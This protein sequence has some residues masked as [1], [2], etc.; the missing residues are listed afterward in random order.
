MPPTWVTNGRDPTRAVPRD[1]KP[2]R[3][4]ICQ[5]T[6]RFRIL[7]A[8][9]TVLM[10]VPGVVT[11]E[12]MRDMHPEFHRLPPPPSEV[13]MLLPGRRSHLER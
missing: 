4:S 7:P 1:V 6:R 5:K 13:L 12:F 10:N 11:R 8:P 9:C 2:S 3:Q